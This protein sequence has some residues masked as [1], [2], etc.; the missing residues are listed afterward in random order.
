VLDVA[1][2]ARQDR[3]DQVAAA[4]AAGRATVTEIAAHLYG[5]F[6]PRIRRPVE[7]TVRA[8]LRYLREHRDLADDITW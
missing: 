3:L 8:H 7:A 1:L 5:E 2:R 6:D 4:V